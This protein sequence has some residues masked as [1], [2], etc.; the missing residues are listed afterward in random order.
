MPKFGCELKSASR[1]RLEIDY[2]RGAGIVRV[3]LDDF[4]QG[5]TSLGYLSA[6]PVHELKIDKSF[7]SDMVVNAAHAAISERGTRSERTA[8][9]REMQRRFE[10]PLG[11]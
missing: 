11:G 10:L 7:V 9:R 2:R 1:S 3:S 6:L 5:Q 4:G 8:L